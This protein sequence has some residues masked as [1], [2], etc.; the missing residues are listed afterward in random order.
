MWSEMT[1]MWKE[2]P[3][4]MNLIGAAAHRKLRAQD[5]LRAAN[6]DLAAALVALHHLGVP[7]CKVAEDVRDNLVL[8]GFLPEHISRLGLSDANVRLALDRQ[9]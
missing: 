9:P 1:D 5:E 3:D 4:P 6:A 8:H 2:V 7:K